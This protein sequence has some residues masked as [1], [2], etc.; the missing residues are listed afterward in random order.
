M[1]ERRSPG[2]N[3]G[4]MA[5]FV[6]LTNDDQRYVW[7]QEKDILYAETFPGDDEYVL[8]PIN[9]QQLSK[10]CP[11]TEDGG[12]FDEFPGKLV[13]EETLHR[14]KLELGEDSMANVYMIADYKLPVKRIDTPDGGAD[15]LVWNFETAEFERNL[16]LGMDLIYGYEPGTNGTEKT[17]DSRIVSEQ[18]FEE[19]VEKLRQ[20]KLQKGKV[21]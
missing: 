14:E 9:V 11:Y 18:E 20:E 5:R 2:E 6:K 10:F 15:F 17:V 16:D 3:K 13:D 21:R 1:F 19:F 7:N 4:K 8:A 12:E